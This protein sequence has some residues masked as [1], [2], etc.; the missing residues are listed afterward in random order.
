[1]MKTLILILPRDRTSSR[2]DHEESLWAAVPVPRTRCANLP[3]VQ[4]R[5]LLNIRLLLVQHVPRSS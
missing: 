3:I 1:M 4:C 2:D 5:G